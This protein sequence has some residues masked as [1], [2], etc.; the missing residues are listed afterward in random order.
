M[1]SVLPVR[2]AAG[3]A[4]LA[5]ALALAAAP[6]ALAAPSAG[7]AAPAAECQPDDQPCKDK[8]TNANEAKEIDEQ[9]KK[10]KESAAKADQDIAKVG[11]DL[12]KCK[13]GSETCMDELAK[14]NG[15]KAGLADMTTKVGAFQPDPKDNAQT[16]VTSTCRDFP[17]SLPAGSTDPGGSPFPVSQLCSL[18]GS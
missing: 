18:L 4:V 17:A 8:E 14:G 3:A 16:A 13:P 2:R 7:P 12:E 1:L 9:Q 10:T 11:K 15:E 5:A 6:A